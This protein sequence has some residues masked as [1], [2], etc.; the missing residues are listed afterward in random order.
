MVVS[1]STAAHAAG[2]VLFQSG[3]SMLEQSLACCEEGLKTAV[4]EAFAAGLAAFEWAMGLACCAA[5]GLCGGRAE[6]GGRLQEERRRFWSGLMDGGGGSLNRLVR[7]ACGEGAEDYCHGPSS[8]TSSSGGSEGTDNESINDLNARAKLLR[9]RSGDTL[10]RAMCRMPRHPACDANDAGPGRGRGLV[11]ECH[12]GIEILIMWAFRLLRLI[13]CARRSFT[14]DGGMRKMFPELDDGNYLAKQKAKGHLRDAT[15]PLLSPRLW[16]SCRGVTTAGDLISK[17]GYPLE[18]HRVRTADGYVI[19]MHRIPARAS[20]RAVFFM[21]GMLDSSVCWV[22]NGVIKSPAF[23]AYNQGFDVWLGNSRNTPPREHVDPSIQN[24]LK[25]WAFTVNELGEQ[26]VRAFVDCIRKIKAAELGSTS[27]QPPESEVS[28]KCKDGEFEFC[29]FPNASDKFWSG[30]E[31]A[32]IVGR[33]GPINRTSDSDAR[34]NGRPHDGLVGNRQGSD[35]S[36]GFRFQPDVGCQH[37]AHR[38]LKA[39]PRG[40]QRRRRSMGRGS[41]SNLQ[42]SGV[43]DPASQECLMRHHS[44]S[45]ISEGD[46]SARRLKNQT[47]S[48]KPGLGEAGHK[49]PQMHENCRNGE[50][51]LSAGEGFFTL[52]AVGHSL[53]AASLLIYVIMSRRSGKTHGL[54]RLILLAPAGFHAHLPPMSALAYYLLKPAA[55]LLTKA[56]GLPGF[57]VQIPSALA[58]LV[59]FKFLHDFR[60]LPA[61]GDIVGRFADLL[62]SGDG[63]SWGRAVCSPHYLS[64]FTPGISLHTG[65]HIVQWFHTGRFGMYDYG[66]P[67]EN[68]VHYGSLRAPDLGEEYGLIDIPVDFMSG[69]NDGVISRLNV[70]MHME[71]AQRGKLKCTYQE[72]D[73][74]HLDFASTMR[75]EVMRAVMAK[76]TLS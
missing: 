4:R 21:H 37:A 19:T 62:T 39:R 50:D 5:D 12:M 32:E 71:A 11:D 22:S 34:V 52:N 36:S 67:V 9:L 72:F 30:M 24:S 27:S 59:A 64:S 14:F 60:K 63:S 28:G 31:M 26:D 73:H 75:E 6:G 48:N 51:Q 41:Q 20:R 66:N 25:Y 15:N 70:R 29:R 58:R 3:N 76:M 16:R 42:A 53:G 2:W 1:V 55:W 40:R 45:F 47:R 17:A 69:T 23:E 10:K 56:L 7:Q 74:S 38:S 33:A 49:Q 57:G 18:E 68:L 65:L 46:S 54:D 43:T 35:C 44:M 61:L 8:A 13:F